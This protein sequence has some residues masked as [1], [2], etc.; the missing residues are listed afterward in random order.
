MKVWEND[1]LISWMCLG[2]TL[3]LQMSSFRGTGRGGFYQQIMADA[4][5]VLVRQ[6]MT[7]PKVVSFGCPV[8]AGIFME[9]SPQTKS[10]AHVLLLRLHLWGTVV[11]LDSPYSN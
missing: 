9:S 10:F 2:L 4:I 7:S 6:L 1:L 8:Y 11:L 5:L 3:F